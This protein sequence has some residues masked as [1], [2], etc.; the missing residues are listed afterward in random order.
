MKMSAIGAVPMLVLLSLVGCGGCGGSGR[1]RQPTADVR[2]T[3][4]AIADVPGV[5]LSELTRDEK[6]VF[7]EVV[8]EEL[9]PCGSPRTL[10]ASLAAGNCRR[11]PFAARFVVSLVVQDMSAEEIG[12]AYVRRYG[13]QAVQRIDLGSSP[14]TGGEMARVTVVEFADFECPYCGQSA[15][16]LEEL[17]RHYEGKV[18]L[19]FKNFPLTAH[20]HS[21]PAALAAMAAHRQGKFWQ[22][23]ERLFANQSSLEREDLFRFAEQIGLDMERFRRDFESE[24][25][26]QAV[27]ADRQQGD[28]LELSGTPTFFVN[29]RRV[30]GGLEELTPM[31]DEELEQHE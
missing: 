26:A 16:A 10:A 24:A 23:Q 27:Q 25:V 31:I 4:A 9:D 7:R 1:S 22:M 19:V 15:S 12:D 5:D 18:R 17:L 30:E 14:V 3:E 11:S 29:G 21:M 20:H 2:E 28:A 8:N 6:R 13:A